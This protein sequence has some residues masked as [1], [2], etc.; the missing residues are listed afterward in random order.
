MED[1]FYSEIYDA[2]HHAVEAEDKHGADGDES[3][4]AALD[5]IERF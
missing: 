5:V 2:N 4:D 3:D 1:S